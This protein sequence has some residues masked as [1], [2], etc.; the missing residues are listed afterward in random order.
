MADTKFTYNEYSLILKLIKPRLSSFKLPMPED[1]VL[2]R[3]DVEFDISR[4]FELAKIESEY[5]SKINFFLSGSI[6]SL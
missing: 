4:A 6:L 1:F 3:H 2:M 5:M